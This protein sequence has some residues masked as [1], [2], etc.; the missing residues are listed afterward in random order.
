MIKL[1][2]ADKDEAFQRICQH[3]RFTTTADSEADT[4]D[5]K[6]F[7][8]TNMTCIDCGKTFGAVDIFFTDEQASR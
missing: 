3:Q 6:H 4:T 2:I 5:P 1:T 7:K 8:V